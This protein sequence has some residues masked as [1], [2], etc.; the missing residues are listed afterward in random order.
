MLKSVFVLEEWLRL[1][2]GVKESLRTQVQFSLV[3]FS[4]GMGVKESLRTEV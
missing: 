3:Y 1:I 4:L 2:E